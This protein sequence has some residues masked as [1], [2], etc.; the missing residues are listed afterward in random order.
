MNVNATGLL[1]FGYSW[2]DPTSH[3]PRAVP[4]QASCL[5]RVPPSFTL[6]GVPV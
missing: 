1:K 4:I 3:V 5:R 2:D 6:T